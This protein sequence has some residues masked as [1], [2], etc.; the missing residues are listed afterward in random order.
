M[1]ASALPEGSFAPVV[2]VAVYTV[3][4]ARGAEG[5][6]VAVVPEYA[7]VPATDVDPCLSVNADV[8]IVDASIVSLNVAEGLIP[9]ATEAAFDAGTTDKTVGGVTSAIVAVVKFQV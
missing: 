4:P 7:T 8:L 6:N 5:V 9:V 3:L 1:A 2:I